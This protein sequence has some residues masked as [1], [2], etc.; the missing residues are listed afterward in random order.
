MAHTTGHGQALACRPAWRRPP[1]QGLRAAPSSAPHHALAA[2]TSRGVRAECSSDIARSKERVSSSSFSKQGFSTSVCIDSSALYRAS[3]CSQWELG[4]AQR[5]G[6]DVRLELRPPWSASW[7]CCHVAQYPEHSRYW[8]YREHSPAARG[9]CAPRA[10]LLTPRAGEHSP[11]K[12][13]SLA[14]PP[15]VCSG[16]PCW[17]LRAL[18]AV[19][20]RTCLSAQPSSLELLSLARHAE[21]RR[22]AST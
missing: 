1:R 8:A 18:R 16:T 5:T 2:R 12:N 7:R 11:D 10:V 4:P 21:Q 20:C 17:V 13:W 3:P 22:S 14:A 6:H 19:V 15:S 9:S